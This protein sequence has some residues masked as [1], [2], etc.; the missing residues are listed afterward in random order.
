MTEV[1]PERTPPKMQIHPS[2]NDLVDQFQ[3]L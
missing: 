1:E 2:I 3:L